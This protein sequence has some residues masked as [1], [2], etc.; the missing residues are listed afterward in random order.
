MTRSDLE[1]NTDPG[2]AISL[3][4]SWLRFEVQSAWEHFF[5]LTALLKVN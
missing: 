4:Q 3:N 2:L 5:S 1:Y